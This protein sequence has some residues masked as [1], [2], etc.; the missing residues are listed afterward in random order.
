MLQEGDKSI[1]LIGLKTFI[2]ET[3]TRKYKRAG[4]G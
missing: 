1:K 4:T 2:Y 3:I